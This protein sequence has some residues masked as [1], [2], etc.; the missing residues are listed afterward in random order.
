M[1]LTYPAWWRGFRWDVERLVR[2]VFMFEDNASADG[3]QGL[4]VVPWF[5]EPKERDAWLS[6]GN[7]YLWVHRLGGHL[8]RSTMPGTDESVVQLAGLSRSRDETNQL[9]EY[10]AT[11]LSQFD[12]G[13]DVRRSTPH[14]GGS[15]STFVKVPGELVGPQLIPDRFRDDRLIPAQ[16]EIHADLPRGLPDYRE[17]LGLDD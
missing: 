11:I 10:V 9:M 4:Q 2:D 1:T 5:P 13:G 3:L 15:T 12:E 17:L 7:G 14:L 16:W 6:Q 8:N